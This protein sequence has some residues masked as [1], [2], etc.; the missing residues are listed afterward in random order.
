MYAEKFLNEIIS[1]RR[2]IHSHPELSQNESRTSEL[3]AKVLEGLGLEVTRNIGGHGV[4]G[5][6]RGK[7][8]GKTIA[9]RAD[10]DALPLNEETGLPYASQTQGVMH[11][12]G[13]DAHT[14]IL[15]GAACALS[16]MKDRLSGNVKF[17]FQP[18]E[19]LNPTG[20]A[21]GMIRDGVLENPHVDSLLALHV[22]PIYET[23][24]IA[25]R[26]GALMAASDRIFLTVHG[27]TAHG[28]RPDQGNDA[29]VTAANIITGLQSVI[30]RSVSPLD[31]AVLTIGTIHG[32]YRYNV[33][34]D[35]V[36]L[37]GT[38]RTL[39]PDTQSRMPELITR[40]AK[41][42]AEAL[43]S[44]CEVEY[45]KGYPPMVND[46]GLFSLVSGSVKKVLGDDAV[47]VA[48]EPDLAAED[49]AFFAR[50]RPAFMAWLG[51]RPHDVKVEDAPKLHNTKFC[52]DENC[53]K[54]GIDYFVQSTLDFLSELSF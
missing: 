38:V 45:V 44:S 27:K 16:E 36:K 50:E 52:P 7:N 19:E 5:L 23:G 30:S 6:L 20:G 8:D 35:T 22:W 25:L 3:V 39:N 13:H 12:C 11:A 54:Y 33:I 15:L 49:F 21:P 51:C 29:I 31:S 40:T 28:S 9:L 1:W 34:P 41:G 24:K 32:G 47:I 17:I 46:A 10:M 53:L 18:A 14:A 43:G 37:E 4:V 2:D 26:S 42:I 48:D